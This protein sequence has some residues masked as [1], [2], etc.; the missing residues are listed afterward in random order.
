MRCICPLDSLLS[1]VDKHFLQ[2]YDSTT[3]TQGL[4]LTWQAQKFPMRCICPLGSLLCRVDKHFLH[5]YDSYDSTMITQG[6]LL[7]WQ[8]QK[9]PSPLNEMHLSIRQLHLSI[10][11]MSKVLDNPRS[12]SLQDQKHPSDCRL[13]EMRIL[14]S[15]NRKK[16]DAWFF[17]S[18]RLTAAGTKPDFCSS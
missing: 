8:A 15:F 16:M 4:F 18:L 2:S 13:Q 5:S 7:T 11:I 3:I 1:R 9:F 17:L 14:L 12:K 6:L 10:R